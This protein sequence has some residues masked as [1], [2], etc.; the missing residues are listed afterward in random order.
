MQTY[1]V[2][3]FRLT[4]CRRGNS[5][6]SSPG[7]TL[8][9]SAVTAHSNPAATTICRV[10]RPLWPNGYEKERIGF[11]SVS[12]RER[13]AKDDLLLL[14]GRHQRGQIRMRDRMTA[15]FEQR[16]GGKRPQF[17]RSHWTMRRGA[18]PFS[19]QF[20]HAVRQ[21]IGVVRLSKDGEGAPRAR[22]KRQAAVRLGERPHEAHSLHSWPTGA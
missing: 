21:G 11:P 10:T 9:C 7:L 13:Q 17:R 14:L 5:N 4:T 15:N 18:S 20:R 19:G 22:G 16:V 1:S 3:A 8:R 6:R 2:R 12:S